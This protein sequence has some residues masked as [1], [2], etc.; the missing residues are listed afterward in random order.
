MVNVTIDNKPVS[1]QLN[2]G[3]TTT[4]PTNETWKV[5]LSIATRRFEFIID[6]AFVT[7]NGKS[8]H[9]LSGALD[10]QNGGPTIKSPA[11]SFVLV[12]DDVIGTDKSSQVDI[13]GVGIQGFVV[14][15]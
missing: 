8:V 11:E 13:E 4:V 7:I 6:Y 3:E 2:E 10:N 1:I 9:G 15:S 5:K 14:S 12:G